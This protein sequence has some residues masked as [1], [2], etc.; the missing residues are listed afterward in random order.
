MKSADAFRDYALQQLASLDGI[1]CRAMFGGYDLYSGEQFFGI[2]H[3]GRL[4]F[5]TNPDSLPDY[6][7]HQAAVFAPSTKPIL[8]NYCEVSF[9]ILEDA[10][11][12][13]I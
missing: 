2:L 9:D 1:H 11:H 6:L 12:L 3:D 4:Y 8:N 5:K 13:N 10:A 7:R